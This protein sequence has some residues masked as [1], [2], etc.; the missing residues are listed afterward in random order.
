MKIKKRHAVIGFENEEF[1][2]KLLS[3][4]KIVMLHGKKLEFYAI[5][6]SDQNYI[7]SEDEEE[8]VDMPKNGK[9]FVYPDFK[10][11]NTIEAKINSCRVSMMDKVQAM[12]VPTIEETR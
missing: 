1:Y 5:P 10:C 12:F 8:I 6:K 3:E 7:V 2:E 4:H 9:G 11:I